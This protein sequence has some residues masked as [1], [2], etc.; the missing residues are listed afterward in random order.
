MPKLNDFSIVLAGEAGQGVKSIESLLVKLLKRSGY[1]LFATKEYM[2]RVRGGINTTSI[3]IADRHVY[4]PLDRIDLF[5][6]LTPDA[7]TRHAG[8]LSEHTVIVCER[9]DPTDDKVYAVPFSVI[10]KELGDERCASMVATGV[11]AGIL[12]LE[13]E[14][15]NALIRTLFENKDQALISA[16]LR[17]AAAG[18]ESGRAI[19]RLAKL[20]PDLLPMP[21]VPDELLLSGT[22]AVAFGAIAGGCDA[23]FSYPMTP[24]TGVLTALAAASHAAGIAVEQVEDEIG[25]IN[26]A[27]GAWYAGGRALVT[28]SGGG[29]ALMGEGLSLAGMTETPV[30]VHLAQR[31]GPATGLPTRTE[32]GDL[33]LAL[34]AGHGLFARILLAPGSLEQAYRLTRQA[35]DLAD[36]FQVPVILLTDQYFVDTCYTLPAFPT[37][38]QTP[39][40]DIIETAEDYRRYRLTDSGISPR[41]IPGLGSGRVCVDSDE[42]D[43]SGRITEDLGG[44]SLRMKEKRFRKL[45]QVKAAALPPERF[46][47][48]DFTTLFV[49]WGSTYHVAQESLAA[50]G[51]KDAALLHFSQVYPLHPDAE[52]YLQQASWIIVIENSQV[53]AFADLL[54]L[55]AGVTISRKILKYD[56]LPFTVESLTAQMKEVCRG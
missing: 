37:E 31:P 40:R 7:L 1:P 15:L 20:H 36:R 6:A 28:T 29:F 42:H 26:M 25:V 52:R 8:R 30:V 11:V 50:S 22:D 13:E 44:I 49:A 34:H 12:A 45:A 48:V 2:S 53:G 4:A 9:A 33:N 17:A 27:L 18:V 39:V 55:E 23:V 19:A 3:R 14:A 41:G 21:A 10:A 46:G 47:T 38:E 35:F 56:G 43:E 32:Q 54:S 51:L 16:N 5:I 24:G